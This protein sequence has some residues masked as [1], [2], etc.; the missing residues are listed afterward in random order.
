VTRAFA[1][2]LTL[3]TG[4][5][6]T[7]VRGNVSAL[8]QVGLANGSGGWTRGDADLDAGAERLGATGVAERIRQQL[9]ERQER[10]SREVFGVAKLDRASGEVLKS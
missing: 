9:P 2:G 5:S 1:H 7:T 6:A 4:Q 3:L 10:Y 8:A